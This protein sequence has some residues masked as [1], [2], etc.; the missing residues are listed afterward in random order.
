MRIIV[1]GDSITQGMWDRNGGW[2]ALLQ[3]YYIAKEISNGFADSQPII[4][5]LGI[6]G[7][8]AAGVVKRLNLE[9][10]ARRW[11]DDPLVLVIAVGQND[12]AVSRGEEAST[13]ELFKGEL[14]Q[15]ISAALPF[16]QHV[17]F[18]GLTPVD[19]TRTDPVDWGQYSYLNERIALFD[20]QIHDLAS[21]KELVSI[22]LFDALA[23]RQ[24]EGNIL[25][26]GLHPDSD[27]HRIIADL[28]SAE[29]EKLL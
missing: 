18:V 13:P 17:I 27:G 19:E 28:V 7:E 20:S 4:F 6:S 9:T 15:I 21:E 23:H 11:L 5:N 29:I 14:E 10:E 8:T 1:F 25:A 12:S 3:Q 24:A 2:V 22:K 26:D 16:T